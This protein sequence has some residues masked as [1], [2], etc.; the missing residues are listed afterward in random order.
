MTIMPPTPDD[1]L[2]LDVDYSVPLIWCKSPHP[3]VPVY[4]CARESGHAPDD[5][6]ATRDRASLVKWKDDTPSPVS[7]INKAVITNVTAVTFRDRQRPSEN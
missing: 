6:H 3:T 7:E 2:L 5:Y 4:I 1:L